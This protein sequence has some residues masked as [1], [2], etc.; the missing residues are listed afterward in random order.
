[1]LATTWAKDYARQVFPYVGGDEKTRLLLAAGSGFLAAV[2]LGKGG[3]RCWT[4]LLEDGWQIRN[5]F[6]A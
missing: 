2:E 4:Q 1:V 3:I 6:S 5:Q